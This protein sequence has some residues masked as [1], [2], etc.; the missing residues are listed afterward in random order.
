MNTLKLKVL[1]VVPAWNEERSI[2]EVVT[3]LRA[4]DFEVLV[5]DDGSSDNTSSIAKSHGALVVRLP[6]NLGVG[7]ALRC[8]FVFALR[9]G[10]DTVVQ[11]D[12]DG[13]HPVAHIKHLVDTVSN[14][15]V[16]MVIGSRFKENA[17]AMRISFLRKVAMKILAQ[18]AT[19]ATQTRITDATSGFRAIRIPLLNEL[20]VN[21]PSYYLGDT[22]EA[23]V[24]AGRAG[25]RVVEISAPITERL[26]GT[27]SARRA[28]AVKLMS[29]ALLSS[30]FRIHTRLAKS[31]D[32]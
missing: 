12:A 9:H 31:N 11:C 23:L 15:N 32:L 27:S 25:Y 1:V 10:Y 14:N 6:M 3:E 7:A 28:T 2:G 17:G 18:S 24:S 26:H 20:A 30:V 22:Y 16:H 19:R 13:Q 29:K 8:G 4:N 21:L 5:V